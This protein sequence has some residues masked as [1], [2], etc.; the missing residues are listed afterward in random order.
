[1]PDSDAD[2][3]SPGPKYCRWA[4]SRMADPAIRLAKGPRRLVALEIML[5]G[6]HADD[7]K[8]HR[9]RTDGEAAAR[10]QGRTK[11]A[12]ADRTTN[13]GSR[14][15]AKHGAV[16][17]GSP[18]GLRFLGS[19]VSERGPDRQ[20][21]PAQFDTV[22]AFEPIRHPA[23]RPSPQHPRDL[24]GVAPETIDAADARSLLVE[25]AMGPAGGRLNREAEAATRGGL[26]G[27]TGRCDR[28]GWANRPGCVVLSG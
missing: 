20:Y 14:R 16:T 9:F 24:R 12:T 15:I 26:R 13:S 18:P 27:P 2:I 6:G 25:I 11:K 17:G 7:A 1:M 28:R 5:S 3:D 23:T 10:G 8:R 4:V 22:L 21:R 19:Q